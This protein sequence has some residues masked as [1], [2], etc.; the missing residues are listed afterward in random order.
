MKNNVGRNDDN[1]LKKIGRNYFDSLQSLPPVRVCLEHEDV[2]FR[3]VCQLTEEPAGQVGELALGAGRT[4][5]LEIWLVDWVVRPAGVVQD[6][7][8][9]L[10]SRQWRQVLSWRNWYLKI[11]N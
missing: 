4:K 8:L 7:V 10:L 2:S 11:K 3:Q 9:V 6:R 5:V 1:N